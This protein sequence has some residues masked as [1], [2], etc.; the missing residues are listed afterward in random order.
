MALLGDRTV[1]RGNDIQ[2]ISEEDVLL[3]Y[4]IYGKYFEKHS[5]EKN[6]R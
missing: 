6:G 4:K 3:F 5:T 2:P 1:I